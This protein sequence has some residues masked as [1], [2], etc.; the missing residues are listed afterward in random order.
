[1]HAQSLARQSFRQTRHCIDDIAVEL[2]FGSKPLEQRERAGLADW[3]SRE[4]LPALD[5]LFSFHAPGEQIIR[6]EQLVFDFGRLPA[7][8]YRYIIREQLLQK[9]MRLIKDQSL[10]L[11]SND[12]QPLVEQRITDPATALK[13]LLDYLRTGQLGAQTAATS[14][15]TAQ[16]PKLHQQ[17]L[18]TLIA[19][20]HIAAQLRALPNRAQWL[21]RLLK[22]FSERHRTVLL[23]QLAP[24]Q[25]EPALALLDIAQTAPLALSAADVQMV[26]QAV[27]EIALEQP[28]AQGHIWFNRLMQQWTAQAPDPALKTIRH[29]QQSGT[30]TSLPASWQLLRAY[31]VTVAEEN[32]P[33]WFATA[34]HTPIIRKTSIDEPMAQ[35]ASAVLARILIQGA[36]EEL[37]QRWPEWTL[38]YKNILIAGLKHYL[39]K[40]EL[41]QQLLLKLPVPF[42]GE[43]LVF[44][45]PELRPVI[46]NLE[47]NADR[48]SELLESLSTQPP[49]TSVNTGIK[50]TANWLRRSYEILAT[51]VFAGLQDDSS[52]VIA[53]PALD[54]LLNELI[55][56]IAG[57]GDLPARELQALW[58]P[59]LQATG[60][61]SAAV[62]QPMQVT[63]IG[64]HQLI[65]A[66]DAGQITGPVLLEQIHNIFAQEKVAELAQRWEEVSRFIQSPQDP[67]FI[68]AIAGYWRQLEIRTAFLS[69]LPLPVLT[70]LLE[71]IAPAYRQWFS[72]LAARK[73]QL[74]R[75]TQS[76]DATVQ[77]ETQ[78]KGAI[79]RLTADDWLR[80][81]YATVSTVLWS[82][83]ATPG[84]IESLSAANLLQD[85][86]R[87]FAGKYQLPAEPLY[88]LWH[89]V[90]DFNAAARD[91]KS[92]AAILDGELKIS[93]LANGDIAGPPGNASLP[94]HEQSISP[95]S[96]NN[97]VAVASATIEPVD[98]KATVNK[99]LANKVSAN[100]ISINGS[101]INNDPSN[102]DFINNDS[103]NNDSIGNGPADNSL[104][105]NIADND[106]AINKSAISKTATNN[107]GEVATDIG[108]LMAK[109]E[110]DLFGWCMS[111]KDNAGLRA[112][113]PQHEQLI[114]R[115]ID[116]FVKYSPGFSPEF[117]SYFLAA[118]RESLQN[119]VAKAEFLSRVLFA[120]VDDKLIDLD[121]IAGSVGAGR[122]A[123]PSAGEGQWQQQEQNAQQGPGVHQQ[124][125]ATRAAQ[126]DSEQQTQ[127]RL[128]R[129]L[130][131]L[132]SDRINPFGLRMSLYYWQRLVEQFFHST[133]AATENYSAL[134]DYIR[135]YSIE[136]VDPNYFYQQVI[137]ALVRDIPLDME[138]FIT[139]SAQDEVPPVAAEGATEVPVPV[140]PPRAALP[141]ALAATGDINT[142]HDV[143]H[144]AG[145]NPAADL[146][147]AGE[148]SAG[149]P[150]PESNLI[151]GIE[152]IT[153]TEPSIGAESSIDTEL[154]TDIISS[155]DISS[156]ADL[157]FPTEA[158]LSRREDSL[159]SPEL[160]LE[161]LLQEPAALTAEQLQQLQRHVNLLLQHFSQAQAS[162]WLRLLRDP[163]H[164]QRLIQQVPG[165]LLHQIAQRLQAAAFAQLDPI[166]KLVTEALA[167]LVPNADPLAIKQA[168]W[169]FV[170]M[171]LFGPANPLEPAEL[172]KRCGEQLAGA[173]GFSDSQRLLQLAERRLAL[174][175]PVAAARPAMSLSDGNE[176]AEPELNFAAGI[177]LNNVGMVLAAPFLPRLFSMFNLLEDGKFIHPGA[178]DRA[179]HLLQYMVTGQS[180][181]P[182]YELVLNKI[183]CGISTSLPISDGIVVT[184]QEKTVIEQ[185]LQSMIQHWRALGSTSISGL[186][187]TFL[188][189]QG[190]LVLDDEYWRLKVQERT[191]DML[192]DRLPWSISM[193]KHAW[194]DKPLRVSW[195]EQ[196]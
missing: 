105:N 83:S 108:Q 141:A 176:S 92:Q 5:E 168:R 67:Q 177:H 78:V 71:L 56:Q 135:R 110:H 181:T 37:L 106:I 61:S 97:S 59:L 55:F 4:L 174:L 130:Q 189:R 2:E 69:N 79:T 178:A 8:D 73:Q 127:Q 184:E 109:S 142:R 72:R 196:S 57:Q 68:A 54:K 70:Q 36:G 113:L 194:M 125:T 90:I 155:T 164:A 89:S 88:F 156:S 48:Y 39:P 1:M 116:S 7:S 163:V 12:R 29:L 193:I 118:I 96:G 50:I 153:D 154:S 123:N 38:A 160:S 136:A 46:D 191:F 99:G 45:A 171:R 93:A 114:T 158:E 27:L 40:A 63:S 120:L 188:Q 131:E 95:D 149:Q 21:A 31:A 87:H 41:R 3:L 140:T 162:E 62:V 180:E 124:Q 126:Q 10:P 172:L 9:L 144:S 13:L 137:H 146:Q 64:E 117:R 35:V 165:H 11:A 23:R 42:I 66:N 143:A 147:G 94:P 17:L 51:Q 91:T 60:N 98:H 115:L 152:H 101:A 84:P 20:Q 179:V 33:E 26:W 34:S 192:L 18:E 133:M 150:M 132:R 53:I 187:E 80:E 169:E 128:A 166:V 16:S 43:L 22:Q 86:V 28:H 47:R 190:W 107:P 15:A 82:S 159:R 24:D 167:L 161:Q 145:E 182:E 104:S 148:Y 75:E 85:V 195:R 173:V 14:A 81:V 134:L 25:L 111:L 121:A 175:K 52:E 102:N 77:A 185:M 122:G 74:L 19:E 157:K 112:R 49:G 30:A 6:F 119:L 100:R 65:T 183:L 170:F 139:R 44:I 129:L 58:Q 32:H 151:T 76:L 138:L 186:R 103:I